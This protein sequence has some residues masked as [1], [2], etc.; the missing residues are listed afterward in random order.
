[1]NEQIDSGK[2][3]R[4]RPPRRELYHQL[5]AEGVELRARLG[6][7]PR[8]GEAADI[9]RGIWYEEAHHST[10]IE[11]NTLLLRQ[12]ERL[13]A[14]GVA[15]GN[16]ELR[17]YL[18]VRGYGTAAEWV[19]RQ[20]LDPTGLFHSGEILSLAKVRQIHHTAMSPVWEV[21]PHPDATDR[22][23]PG[24]FREHDIRPFPGGMIPVE[25]PLVSAR[26]ETWIADANSLDPDVVAFP[27]ALA[28]LHCRF[29][30]IH[31][32]LDGNGRTGRLV[33]NL[34]LV[35][36]GYPPAI[37]YKRDRSRYLTALR[38]ADGGDSG[39]LG[40]M[41]AR[42]IL[43]N[44]YRFVIPAVAGPARLVPLAA[45]ATP[46]MTAP[47][48]RMAAARGRLKAVRGPDGRWRSSRRWVEGYQAT[49]YR[50]DRVE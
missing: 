24:S 7:L 23:T 8:P 30:Q 50:R 33:L 6:G 29:E 13:L 16:R 38:R 25:W 27:E 45:L 20:A 12:V 10:A 11:G 4:G 5:Y 3:R 21:A 9:W 22:E 18:E 1:M 35:R 26:M 43:D 2:P 48:L 47:A 19:Y 15:V 28:E 46:D 36:L 41:I 32:F 31:P 17:E 14:D 34:I 44:L 49:R 42:A 39:P 40:E 37:I